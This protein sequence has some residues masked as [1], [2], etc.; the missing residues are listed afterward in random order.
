MGNL[1]FYNHDKT[2]GAIATLSASGITTTKEF[3]A[4]SFS[5]WTHVAAAGATILFYNRGNGAAA[6]GTLA[7]NGFTTDLQLHPGAFGT[8]THVVPTASGW[9]FYNRM[10]GAAAIGRLL[11][12]GLVKQFITTGS[13]APGS[14]SEWTHIVADGNTVLFYNRLNASGAIGQITPT[15]LT[16]TL[17]MAPGT[18]GVWTH[19]VNH[20]PTVL[21]YNRDSG[22]GAIAT[23]G[24]SGLT[25]NATYGA[26]AFSPWTHVATDGA[27]VLFYSKETGSAAVGTLAASSFTTTRSYDQGAFGNWSHVVGESSSGPEEEELRIAV[28]LCHWH[29]P[30]AFATVLS[31]DFYRHYVFDMGAPDGI[32]RFWFDQSGGQL[33]FTGTVNDWIPLS[34]APDDPSIISQ[35]QA[36]GE[37]AIADA[38]RAGWKPG[39]EQAI[40]V[41]V[42]TL[43]A[44][45]VDAGALG[46]PVNVAGVNREVALLHGDSA[47]WIASSGGNV[48][49]SNFRHDFNCHEVGHLVGRFFSFSHAFGP[50]GVY[51][52]PYCIMAAKTYGGLAPVYDVWQAG[53]NRPPEDETKGPGLDGATRAACGWAR[54]RR[55]TPADLNQGVDVWL[56]H[57]GDHDSTSPQVIEIAAQTNGAAATYTLEFRTKLAERDQAI[58][59]A[60]V[61]CQRE[62]SP[63]ATDGTWKPRSST[64]ITR[65]VIP[66]AGALPSLARAGVVKADVLESKGPWLHLRLTAA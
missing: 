21:F 65:A 18:F 17:S 1:L 60:L 43:G 29:R 49:G 35:R 56:A 66:P 28:L 24:A 38:Q 46:R 58:A 62:G 12:T 42:A 27:D 44:A 61:L 23:L 63:W 39:N 9:F 2:S 37:L 41:V 22:S 3:P 8:W 32:G 13:L 36:L 34:K 25:T 54:V 64:Y 5:Q 7:P 6:F 20:G 48:W 33:R 53:S 45:G 15:G 51:D 52:H 50:N 40:V 30:P 47:N 59:P 11:S 10:T 55:L 26:G 19:V 4:G 31:A 16:T 14:L 57:L